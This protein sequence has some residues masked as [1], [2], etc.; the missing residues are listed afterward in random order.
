MPFTQISHHEVYHAHF[1]VKVILRD[2]L[3]PSGDSLL[4][5]EYATSFLLNLSEFTNYP[6]RIAESQNKWLNPEALAV[7][8][9]FLFLLNSEYAIKT[10]NQRCF[11]RVCR[12]SPIQVYNH[13][14][15]AWGLYSQK[16][17]REH[18]STLSTWSKGTRNSATRP[19]RD[20]STTTEKDLSGKRYLQWTRA[21]K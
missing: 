13:Q 18:S 9:N 21:N 5:E 10:L 12:P 4:P 19:R 17:Q 3:T 14:P 8:V 15:K 7:Y 1:F 11:R 20:F 6:P 16:Y 2:F